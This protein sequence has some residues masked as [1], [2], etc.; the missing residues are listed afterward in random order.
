MNTEAKKIK[1]CYVSSVDVTVKFILFNQ[2]KFLKKEGYDVYVV[3]SEGKWAKDIE[4][5]GIK[6][7]TI[8]FK[9][10]I[11]PF[12][13]LLALAQ[14][15][16]Y[17]KKEKFDIIHT[18][19]PKASLVGQWAAKFA[20]VPI[21]VNTVHGFYFQKNDSR[22]KR[23]FFILIEKISAKCSSLILFVNRED[24]KT[25][26]EENIC[27]SDIIRYFGGGIDTERFDPK[28]F[29]KEFIIAKKKELNIPESFKIIFIV[30][31]LVREKG[32]L[33]LFEAL[34]LILKKIPKIIL[35]SVGSE[36]PEKKD[37]IDPKIAESYG[38]GKNMIFLGER[39]D[40]N[41]IFSLVDV[42]ALPS[43]REGLGMAILEAS[44]MEKPVV[45]TN[46][47]GCREAVD[48]GITGILVPVNNS[49]KLAEAIIYFLERP[50]KA[51][52]SG[53][54][55]RIK[56]LK[57]FD[58]MIIFDRIKECYQEL[59]GRRLNKSVGGKKIQKAI[60]RFFDF[61]ISLIG[62][63]LLLPAFFILAI[64]IKFDS[65]GPIFFRQERVGQY[66]KIF[67][68]WKFRTMVQGA[69]KIGLGH[70]V[71]KSDARITKIGKFLRRFAIDE[72]PQFINI[73]LGE[74]SLVGPRTALPHQVEKYSELEKR[75]FEVKPG[76]ASLAHIRGWNALPW[77]DR[78]KLDIWYIDN[79]S[80]WLDLE[81]LFKTAIVVLLG[82]G[83][84]GESGVTKD[85]E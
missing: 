57:E 62:L 81:I 12:S 56:V 69:E 6:V 42:F 10:K 33:N 7:K 4:R 26:V 76:M 16:L 82:K 35:L 55:G 78:I 34:K 44:A 59:I 68:I 29:S 52:E 28:L 5:E 36:E 27:T 47:R 9:R 39:E 51:R 75:R 17:F 70:V 85:Y 8:R 74:M 1:I 80:I 15:F 63:I 22:R 83:Q 23:R 71:A 2:L 3:C 49:E 46:I 31:R 64:L 77:K 65:A 45:A 58:D 67:K 43:Y 50:E 60:K 25:A 40:V 30:A 14:L 54:N 84:Y 11:S 72:M 32:Y 24:M 37:A 18:H 66:G 20:G 79:W 21:I 13:D 19:T 41:E 53:K 73:I 48:N 38:I 61:L